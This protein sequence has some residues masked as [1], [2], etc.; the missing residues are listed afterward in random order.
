MGLVC[1][2]ARR[3]DYATGMHRVLQR[4]AVEPPSHAA[5][6]DS[7]TCNPRFQRLPRSPRGLQGISDAL[8]LGHRLSLPATS[9][10]K[11]DD[12]PPF[13]H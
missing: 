6:S 7:Y 13:D 1:P 8:R 12:Q 5:Y 3:V 11:S 10:A 2:Q 4:A 9:M